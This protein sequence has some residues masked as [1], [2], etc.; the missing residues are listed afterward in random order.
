MELKHNAGKCY[1]VKYEAYS[2]LWDSLC[3]ISSIHSHTARTD[4]CS[5]LKVVTN[6]L[7]IHAGMK[8][9]PINF[10]HHYDLQ[11]V[12]IFRYKMS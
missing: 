10:Q 9:Y 1:Y 11:I 3:L 8:L 7:Y 2:A 4:I 6:I 12:D 5:V